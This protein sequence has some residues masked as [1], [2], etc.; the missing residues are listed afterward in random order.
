MPS[1]D[2]SRRWARFSGSSGSTSASTAA[3]QPSDQKAT[4]AFGTTASR[5]SAGTRRGSSADDRRLVSGI[6]SAGTTAIA[7]RIAPSAKAASVPTVSIRAPPTSGPIRPKPPPAV[8]ARP[9]RKPSWST[10]VM[11]EIAARPAVHTRPAASP[12]T[13]R[14]SARVATPTESAKARV[15]AARSTAAR[16]MAGRRP[17]RS[18]KPTPPRA[19]MSCPT[20]KAAKM[21]A[22]TVVEKP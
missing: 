18:T 20:G 4:R 19:V 17:A 12:C 14:A 3:T 15:A 8:S 13:R 5:R 7:G 16:I 1:D 22:A 10:G 2:R 21:S 11:S 9:I 6:A